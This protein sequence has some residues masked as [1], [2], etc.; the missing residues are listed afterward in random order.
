M[1]QLEL[2]DTVGRLKKWY[3][4]FGKTLTVHKQENISLAYNLAITLLGL[5]QENENIY[6]HKVLY[7]NAYSSFICKSRKL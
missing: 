3:N 5:T 7:M 2:S 1:E 6:P 4:H